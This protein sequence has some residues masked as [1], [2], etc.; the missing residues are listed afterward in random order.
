MMNAHLQLFLSPDF[1]PFFF[2]YHVSAI[3]RLLDILSTVKEYLS[4]IFMPS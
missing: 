3:K 1:S 2:I 4:S